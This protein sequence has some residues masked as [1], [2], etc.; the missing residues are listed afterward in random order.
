MALA[1]LAFLASA[2]C[3]GLAS[4]N[5]GSARSLIYALTA[6]GFMATAIILGLHDVGSGR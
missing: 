1:V 3:L 2:I 5:A 4:R 6:A